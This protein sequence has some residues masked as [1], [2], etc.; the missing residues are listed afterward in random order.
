MSTA[1]TRSSL[2]IFRFA[3]A[4]LL[5]AIAVALV[6]LTWHWPLVWDAQVFHYIHF[7]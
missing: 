4:A 5:A 1:S 7:V 3:M 6:V 2:D